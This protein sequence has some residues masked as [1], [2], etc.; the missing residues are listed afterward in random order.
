M[1]IEVPAHEVKL[2]TISNGEG[3]VPLGVDDTILPQLQWKY[4]DGALEIELLKDGES[5]YVYADRDVQ[6]NCDYE[7]VGDDVYLVK[8][9]KRAERVIIK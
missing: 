1:D 2:F 6:S 7:K 8:G 5:V 3:I 4:Q 9:G